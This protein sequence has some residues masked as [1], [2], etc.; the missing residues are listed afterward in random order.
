MFAKLSNTPRPNRTFVGYMVGEVIIVSGENPN[1][2][3][4]DRT[5]QSAFPRSC[6]WVFGLL[7]R[8]LSFLRFTREHP[9][10]ASSTTTQSFGFTPDFFPQPVRKR[11]RIG[12]FLS[13]SSRP[14]TDDVE[15]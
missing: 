15:F 14:E 1:H 11:F 7:Q 6:P 4:K 2:S 8:P 10:S 9:A 12:F 5:S 3:S 13:C